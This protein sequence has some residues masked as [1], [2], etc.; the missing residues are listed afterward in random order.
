MYPVTRN[1]TCTFWPSIVAVLVWIDALSL[2]YR[3][4]PYGYGRYGVSPAGKKNGD[5]K[6]AS[7][8]VVSVRI[9]SLNGMDI[10]HWFSC[11]GYTIDILYWHRPH[12]FSA[13]G[14]LTDT[15]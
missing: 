6:L 5:V 3:Y 14:S 1:F 8:V 4:V 11:T 15:S 2:L 9:G 13:T 12:W 10:R 7:T